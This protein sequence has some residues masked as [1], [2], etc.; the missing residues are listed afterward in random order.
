[1][2]L[3]TIRRAALFN[4][5]LVT[6]MKKLYLRKNGRVR[7]Y[8]EAWIDGPDA[9][10]HWGTVGSRGLHTASPL[11]ADLSDEQNVDKHLEPW[12]AQDYAPIAAGEE[13]ALELTYALTTHFDPDALA[14]RHALEGRL[15]ELLG[16]TGLGH[17]DGGSIGSGTMEVFCFVVDPTVA[18]EVIEADLRGTEFGDY[19]DLETYRL[20]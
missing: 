20:E 7:E 15:D 4:A 5:E 17:V 6:E 10:Q 9:V 13:W 2:R 11:A 19:A 16:W 8:H 14:K 3:A 12:A 18:A 1:M